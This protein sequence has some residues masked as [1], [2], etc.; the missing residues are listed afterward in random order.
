[1]NHGFEDKLFNV[2]HADIFKPE[3]IIDGR[4]NCVEN[5]RW[6]PSNPNRVGRYLDDIVEMI[7]PYPELG[8]AYDLSHAYINQEPMEKIIEYKDKIVLFHINDT[9]G[10]EDKHLPVGRGEIDYSKFWVILAKINYRG[11]LW[12]EK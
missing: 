11:V 4:K 2:I 9:I 10:R 7:K 8:I 6:K 12:I 5:V 3:F 1:M